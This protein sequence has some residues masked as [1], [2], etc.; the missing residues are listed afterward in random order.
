MSVFIWL[1][2]ILVVTPPFIIR[3]QHF[4][5]AC[6]LSAKKPVEKNTKKLVP[7]LRVSILT[8]ELAISEGKFETQTTQLK[9]AANEQIW[10]H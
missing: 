10:F 2:F 4:D 1:C 6:Y 7:S 5:V 3:R 8:R 9:P